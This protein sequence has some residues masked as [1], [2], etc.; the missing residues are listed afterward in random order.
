MQSEKHCPNVKYKQGKL[1]Q[2]KGAGKLSGIIHC[3][4]GSSQIII[5]IT[6]KCNVLFYW[7]SDNK[8]TLGKT[9]KSNKVCA[10]D[11]FLILINVTQSY[12]GC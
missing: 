9:I 5:K 1:N 8:K 10:N 3:I 12:L 2:Y 4:Q 6:T 11:N 7:S